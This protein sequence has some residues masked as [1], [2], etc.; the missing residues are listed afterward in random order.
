MEEG[1]GRRVG[2]QGEG[3]G[4]GGTEVGDGGCGSMGGSGGWKVGW[5]WVGPGGEMEGGVRQRLGN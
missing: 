5:G 1:W 4:V 2:A 3:N